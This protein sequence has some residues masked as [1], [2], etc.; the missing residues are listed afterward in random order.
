MSN[1]QY[2]KLPIQLIAAY[3]AEP[4]DLIALLSYTDHFSGGK[5]PMTV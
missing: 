5:N 4:E 3:Q 1:L 2:K